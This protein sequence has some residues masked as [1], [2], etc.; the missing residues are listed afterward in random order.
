[1]IWA[2]V[3]A[4]VASA[5]FAW[6]WFLCRKVAASNRLLAE[7]TGW[8]RAAQRLAGVG[9]WD[10]NPASGEFAIS[11]EAAAI[12]DFPGKSHLNFAGFLARVHAYD[13]AAV[14]RAF[15]ACADNGEPLETFWRQT[16]A[17]GSIRHLAAR[18]ECG[19]AGETRVCRG[20]F[21]D[22]TD[23]VRAEA[24][25]R[26][27]FTLLDAFVA[28]APALIHFKD[29]D[30]RIKLVNKAYTEFTGRLKEDVIGNLSS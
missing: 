6:S 30:G 5:A 1:M 18:G 12:L 28:D 2:E 27:N 9:A 20:A 16:D 13:R 11:H 23:R 3:L 24:A 21:S 26:Q 10:W 4:L 22:V 29:V 15:R 25:M 17:T 19:A 7:T 14:E 8:L